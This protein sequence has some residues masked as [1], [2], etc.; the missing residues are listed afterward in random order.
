MSIAQL[1]W[2]L[3]PEDVADASQVDVFDNGAPI[4]SVAPTVSEFD[5]GELAS[6]DHLFSVIVRSR[7]GSAFDSDASNSVTVNVPAPSVKL[8]PVSDLTAVLA[9]APAP[10]A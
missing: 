2:T 10:A 7:A 5:T 9:D 1:K 8:T 3:P 4:G 6:G